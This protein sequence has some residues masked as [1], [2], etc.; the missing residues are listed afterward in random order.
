MELVWELPELAAD[1][2]AYLPL[3]SLEVEHGF[4]PGGQCRDLRFACPTRI[5]QVMRNAGLLMRVN[6]SGFEVFYDGSQLDCLRRYATDPEQPLDLVFKA[7]ARDPLF[8]NYTEPE[9]YAADALLYFDNRRGAVADAGRVRLTTA[10]VV[11]MADLV[12]LD[13]PQLVEVLDRHDRLAHPLLVANIHLDEADLTPQT[14]SAEIAPVRHYVRFRSRQTFWMYYLQGDLARDGLTI[15]DLDN[16][17]QFELLGPEALSNRQNALVYCSQ[18]ALPLRERS[19]YR[20]QLREN[21]GGSGRVLLR[22]LPVASAHQISRDTRNG[23]TRNGETV[24]VS[25][26]FV[27]G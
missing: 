10:E 26:I 4:F 21:N 24:L 16:Q 8:V 2:G 22:R 9:V 17:V 12:S 3:F 14:E 27:I 25:K 7:F 13:S 5:G 6:P 20:F 1:V 23:D 15:T 19:D 18:T 11:S